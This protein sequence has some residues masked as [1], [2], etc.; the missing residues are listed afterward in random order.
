M[1]LY[2]GSMRLVVA[3][4]RRWRSGRRVTRWQWP[5]Y[6]TLDVP[7]T[8]SVNESSALIEVLPQVPSG[9]VQLSV[10]RRNKAESISEEEAAEVLS[11]FL[12]KQDPE[13]VTGRKASCLIDRCVAG[14]SFRTA[15]ETVD[16][17]W[18][19]VVYLW[20]DFALT[21]TYCHDGQDPQQRM[22]ARQILDSV[23]R[24]D[25]SD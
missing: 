17:Y 18:D 14:A 4:E 21:C 15:A 13:E 8:W 1:L 11:N 12:D 6:F 24:D 19:V 23:S 2:D 3:F 10:L 9:A 5:G 20:D 25:T 22:E 16:L 7:E